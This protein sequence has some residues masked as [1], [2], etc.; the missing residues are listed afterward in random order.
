MITDEFGSEEYER[1]VKDLEL[2]FENGF[3]SDK[4]GNKWHNTCIF[5]PNVNMGS[6]N[7]FGPYC[8]IGMPGEVADKFPNDGAV[9]IRDNNVFAGM[10]TIDAS[11]NYDNTRIGN[12]CFLMKQTHIG[13]DTVICDGVR[14]APRARIG[15][16]CVIY[17]SSNIGMNATIHQRV[18][19]KTGCMIGMGAVV[20]KKT[21]L[22]PWQKYAGVP[23]KWIGS[24]ESF[25]K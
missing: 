1:A 22:R 5:G 13:H 21:V 24:N 23:V 3:L 14:I 6:N 20:T 15:G 19:I 10:L 16:E 11:V 2:N 18:N 12:N 7:Y 17:E 8:V 25:K 9:L 4:R